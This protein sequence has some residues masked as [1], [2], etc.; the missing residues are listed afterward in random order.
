MTLG[1]HIHMVEK[2]GGIDMKEEEIIF[3]ESQSG[4][5]MQQQYYST[6]NKN[7]NK[8][9]ILE[10]INQLLMIQPPAPRVICRIIQTNGQ[11]VTGFIKDQAKNEIMV[12]TRM[13]EQ[14]IP[15][16][17]I[18]QIIPISFQS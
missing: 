6:T 8:Q 5:H 13:N 7:H 17:D 3:P 11:T 4:P 9:A 14:S 16:T 12:E 1:R 10:K 15:I 2:N 18:E